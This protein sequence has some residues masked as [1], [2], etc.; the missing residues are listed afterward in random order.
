MSASEVQPDQD[1]TR[2]E[3]VHSEVHRRDVGCVVVKLYRPLDG[4]VR[5]VVVREKPL[6]LVQPS[7]EL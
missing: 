6:E 4:A 3:L 1:P 5:N 2:Y 7:K